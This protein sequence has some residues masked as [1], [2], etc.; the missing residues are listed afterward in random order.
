MSMYML[1]LPAGKSIMFR[2]NVFETIG[3]FASSEDAK[4]WA[5]DQPEFDETDFVIGV[6]YTVNLARQDA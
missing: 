6:M 3:P 2:G 1:Y 4:E 5:D